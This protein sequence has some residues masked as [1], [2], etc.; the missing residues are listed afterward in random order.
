M[1]TR[2]TRSPNAPASDRPARSS[3]SGVE[4]AVRGSC[5][6]ALADCGAAAV[7]PAAACAGRFAVIARGVAVVPLVPVADGMLSRLASLVVDA[8]FGAVVPDV[9]TAGAPLRFAD[10]AGA[11]SARA[12][13]D[14]IVSGCDALDGA[15]AAWELSAVVVDAELAVLLDAVVVAEFSVMLPFWSTRSTF[16]DL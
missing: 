14:G 15:A 7:A 3:I 4:L 2:N 16:A 8:A 9:P 1:R 10:G 12:V 11:V 5:R 6:F 13:C